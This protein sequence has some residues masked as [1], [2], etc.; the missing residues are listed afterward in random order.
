MS[1]TK[2]D[3]AQQIDDVLAFFQGGKRWT[4][5]K[6][7]VYG[8]NREVHYAENFFT[9]EEPFHAWFESDFPFKV[10]GVMRLTGEPARACLIGGMSLILQRRVSDLARSRL[11]PPIAGAI[12]QAIKDLFGHNTGIIAF[13]DQRSTT[14][15]KSEQA[16]LYA[17]ELVL[18]GK[19]TW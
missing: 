11:R 18:K 7:F 6:L 1:E 3:V 5:G 17:K 19:I 15:A 10:D 16:L 12:D 9:S 2:E 13:N 4:R 8:N 14:W